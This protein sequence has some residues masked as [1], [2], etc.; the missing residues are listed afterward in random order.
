MPHD[1]EAPPV[2]LDHS[3]ITSYARTSDLPFT[4]RPN[5]FVSGVELERVP[6]LAIG[7]SV[8]RHE[9]VLLFCD[10]AWHVLAVTAHASVDDAKRQA[11]AAYPGVASSWVE[12]PVSDEQATE[13]LDAVW[14]VEKCSLCARRPDEV[15][16]LVERGGLRICDVCI[17][18][19]HESISGSPGE[20]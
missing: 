13:Y 8:H 12:R 19:L 6:H 16:R 5:V 2:V 3:L 11:E 4:G 10:D 14:H 9:T 7:R 20:R 17:R 18:E 15:D 1:P